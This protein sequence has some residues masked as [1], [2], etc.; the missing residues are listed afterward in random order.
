MNVALV[1]ILHK[2]GI[3]LVFTN[4]QIINLLIG[5]CDEI[6]LHIVNIFISIRLN[7]SESLSY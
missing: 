1:K 3:Y 6:N 2:N 7:Y 5:I 4:W